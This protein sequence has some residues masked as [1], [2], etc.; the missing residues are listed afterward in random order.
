MTPSIKN[1]SIKDFKCFL[2]HHGLKRIRVTDGHEVWCGKGL[3]RPVIFQTHID[4]VPLF[5]IKNNLRTMRLTLAD[6]RN[7]I[8]SQN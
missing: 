3:T 1:V 5:I 6:L 7:Y 2:L 4:P 8:N